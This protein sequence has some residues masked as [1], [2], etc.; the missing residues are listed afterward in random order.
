[1]RTSGSPFLRRRWY[2]PASIR[3]W[4]KPADLH[5]NASST[6]RRTYIETASADSEVRARP[7]RLRLNR[8]RLWRHGRRCPYPREDHPECRDCKKNGTVQFRLLCV[9]RCAFEARGAKPGAIRCAARSP[10]RPAL[11]VVR[12]P[13]NGWTYFPS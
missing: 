12:F 5:A 3:I 8:D 6:Q 9:C 13:R 4:L 11:P 2:C 7:G 1:M 10:D